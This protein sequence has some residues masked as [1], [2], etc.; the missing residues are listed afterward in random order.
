M[1]FLQDLTRRKREWYSKE[2]E[3]LRFRSL[4][5]R[6]LQLGGESLTVAER[7]YISHFEGLYDLEL[8]TSA[9]CVS[10][11]V[12]SLITIG[13][14]RLGKRLSPRTMVVNASSFGL[15]IFLGSMFAYRATFAPVPPLPEEEG[16][17]KSN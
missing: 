15:A 17:K 6:Q 8:A 11:L 4:M 3:N 2:A 14:R 7:R 12:L 1:S 16:E 13:Y 9:A 5:S 10:S